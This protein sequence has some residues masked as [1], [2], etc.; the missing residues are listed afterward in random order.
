MAS[1]FI[2][3]LFD[4]GSGIKP[5]SGALLYF[6]EVG[7]V[8]PKDTYTDEAATIPSSNPVVANSVGVFD[9]IWI[10]GDYDVLLEDK[11]LV[12]QW[13]PESVGEGL[14][15]RH[16]LLFRQ[17][18]ELAHLVFPVKNDRADDY[19]CGERARQQKKTNKLEHVSL[20]FPA[21]SCGRC[22][23]GDED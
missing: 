10:V 5:P 14:C 17:L 19:G 9:A 3:P 20:P 11:N 4:V 22:A 6:Y 21:G 15:Q 16:I 12:Q 1:R 13:G 23:A 7:T 2:A 18:G 8:D